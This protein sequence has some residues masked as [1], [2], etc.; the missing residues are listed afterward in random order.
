[1]HHASSFF[2]SFFNI[3]II[4]AILSFVMKAAKKSKAANRNGNKGENKDRYESFRDRQMNN[5]QAPRER[6][7]DPGNVVIPPSYQKEIKYANKLTD[8]DKLQLKRCSNCGG[9]IPLSMMK[10]T[11]CGQRQAGCGWVA[12]IAVIIFAL[13][14]IMAVAKDSGFPIIYYLQQ[15]FNF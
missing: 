1:M 7:Q 5:D 8:R 6:T 14:I 12:A 15:I 13:I 10:C 3:I 11:I 4:F 2:G 9:E